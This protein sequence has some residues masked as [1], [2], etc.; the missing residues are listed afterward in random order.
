MADHD[1]SSS[2]SRSKYDFTYDWFS[3]YVP[4]WNALLPSIKPCK[5][6]EI[7]SFEGRSACYLIESVAAERDLE[8]HCIDTWEG[9]T[10]HSELD[11]PAVEER[12]RKN[13]A[14]AIG[15]VPHDV[16]LVVHRT[17]SLRAL[18]QLIVSGH[19][20]SF[21]LIYVDGSHQAPDVLV[22]AVLAFNLL[23]I[24]GFLVF[25]DYLLTMEPLGEQNPFNMPKPAIDSFVNIYQRKLLV[26]PI[27]LS[28][29]YMRKLS[30]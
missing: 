8:I 13:T 5:V 10:E 22:D 6:L 27:H 3:G 25:D 23:R 7:G 12:F 17:T 18:T 14:L 11:M 4:I 30:A 24:D 29:L 28:Q 15:S 20:S 9:G 16:N 1:A 21:D 19:T 26:L 2:E